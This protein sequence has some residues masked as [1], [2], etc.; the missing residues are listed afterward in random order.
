MYNAQT[1][2]KPLDLMKTT[3][4]QFKRSALL[5]I[6]I[7]VACLLTFSRTQASV[8]ALPE[9]TATDTHWRTVA[10]QD[11]DNDAM[12][13]TDGYLLYGWGVAAGKSQK[14]YDSTTSSAKQL[15]SRPAYITDVISDAMKLWSGQPSG[16]G[17]Y[18]NLEVPDGA[19]TQQTAVLLPTSGGSGNDIVL[20]IYRA[21]SQPFRLTLIIGGGNGGL[22]LQDVQFITIDAGSAGS[23][24]AINT[25]LDQVGVTYS[26]FD[27][28]EGLDPITITVNGGGAG[29]N[30]HLTGLAFDHTD[31]PV[32]D[33]QPSGGT[34]LPGAQ[35]T[36][37]AHAIGLE[38]LSYQWLKD[39]DTIAD[40]TS[41]TL[42][43]SGLSTG[44][45]AT[46]SIVV[47][48][49]AG[50]ITNGAAT[51]VLSNQ[52]P[53]SVS[54]YQSLVMGEANLSS[55][56]TFDL[57]TADDVAGSANGTLAGTTAF[58]SGFGGS[59]DMALQL[60]GFGRVNL[61]QVDSFDFSDGS[62][63][64]E[65]WLR[66]DWRGDPGYDPCLVAD[67]DS[68][69]SVNYSI[70]MSASKN[71]ITYWNG[72]SAVSVAIPDAGTNWHHLAVTFDST[73]PANPLWT[74]YWDGAPAGTVTQWFGM[75]FA[76][77]QLGSSSSDGAEQWIGAVDEVAFYDS[78]TAPDR[79][80]A[81]YAA[82]LGDTPPEISLQP[83]GVALFEGE[84]LQLTVGANGVD[85][86]YQW[87][88]NG[89]AI[90]DATNA[91]LLIASTT[92]ADNGDY[93]A[94]VSNAAGAVQSDVAGVSV[95]SPNIE[96]YQ[97][98]V[99]DQPGLISYY[100][101]DDGTANDSKSINPG[102]LSGGNS[103]TDGFY[104][105]SGQALV[106]DGTGF[107]EFG[108]VPAFNFTNGTGTIEL[109]LRAD[110][111][112]RPPYNPCIVAAR[113]GSAVEYSIHMTKDKRQI[114]YWNGH[115]TA[116]VNIPDAG[117]NWHFLAL[118]F[119]G[120]EWQVY[121]DGNYIGMA[122]KGFGDSTNT[123]TQLGAS[124][125]GAGDEWWMGALDEVS[126]YSSA[127]DES[128]LR[129]HYNSMVKLPSPTLQFGASD[130]HLLLS[131]PAWA[132]Q[133]FILES[134]DQL[135]EAN[136]VA[137]PAGPTNSLITNMLPGQSQFYRLRQ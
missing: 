84:P 126:F 120:P 105:S 83:A 5:L 58:A 8:T 95:G 98:A 91:D 29:D 18:G 55:F 135:S 80:L 16:S 63:T 9:D 1:I 128:T 101:F 27:I 81:H 116:T 35:L 68:T 57:L 71:A 45:V 3:A 96:N 119:N 30:T 20:T 103:F 51:I 19:T 131:W 115:G 4:T 88:R 39:G 112:S 43:F 67:Q 130:G 87:F 109:W 13:G 125:T 132:Q 136:W 122:P 100:T 49:S 47:T 32:A 64:I 31:A 76:Q 77:T 7:G 90:P 52:A 85:L 15:W 25:G 17:S 92:P 26:S 12:Y 54:A 11:V 102:T 114:S 21:T 34:F 123:P 108:E 72:S 46:Y 50:Q 2:T 6:L 129:A 59:P 69:Y 93:Y 65:M 86:S 75:S 42:V 23:T 89:E 113:D 40:A 137:V 48:N 74:V 124:S 60:D 79:I 33:V 28:G 37:R 78:P 73:D 44:D 134:S 70:H 62:G 38:P 97:A 127:L 110:W 14:G 111:L 22:N 121:W 104:G 24:T 107:V 36:L 118:T 106:L 133:R 56:Y 82:G 41:E 117:T 66:A 94:V 53:P 61:G 10:A 99:Q